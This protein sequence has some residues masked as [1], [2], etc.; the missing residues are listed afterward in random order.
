MLIGK[1]DRSLFA[2]A[3]PTLD[4]ASRKLA[5]DFGEFFYPIEGNRIDKET[6][7]I[8]TEALAGNVTSYTVLPRAVRERVP[9][10]FTISALA[11]VVKPTTDRYF[12]VYAYGKG[13]TTGDTRAKIEEFARSV[14]TKS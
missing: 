2:S 7:A 3:A 6:A 13:F 4:L 10:G 1:L 9:Q 14:A 12:V 8:E 5:H 11:F